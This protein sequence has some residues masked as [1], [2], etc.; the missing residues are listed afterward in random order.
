MNSAI[1]NTRAAWLNNTSVGTTCN[2][3]NFNYG[4]YY[5]S[6]TN[7]I[8]SAGFFTRYLYSLWLGLLALRYLHS[9]PAVLSLSFSFFLFWFGFLHGVLCSLAAH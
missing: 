3:T 9:S 6:V 5:N 7:G 2:T 8:A 4:I 1:N